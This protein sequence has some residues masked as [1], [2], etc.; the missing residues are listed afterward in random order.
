MLLLTLGDVAALLLDAAYCYRCGMNCV[1]VGHTMSCVKMTEPIHVLFGMWTR[2][3][4]RNHVLGG[5]RIPLEEGVIL[6]DISQ[7]VVST[8]N[9]SHA[10]S[11]STLL[12]R[13]QQ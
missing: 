5:V 8:G 6:E 12:G 4:P 13:W 11:I 2:V 9:I 3:G 1:S 7:P 10:V